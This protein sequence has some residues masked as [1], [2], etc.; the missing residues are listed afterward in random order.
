MINR[1]ISGVH[2]IMMEK[3]ALAGE[4]GGCT[5][6]PLQ[7]ITCSVPYAPAEMAVTL[8][9]FHLYPKFTL[10]HEQRKS[11]QS[12]EA[13]TVSNEDLLTGCN[14]RKNITREKYSIK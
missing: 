14:F 13:H 11:L 9:V 8:S 7:H 5:L 6:T 4:G 10:W 2:P 1:E 12:N 3:S